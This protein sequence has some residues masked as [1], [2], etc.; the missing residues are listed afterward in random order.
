M[1]KKFYGALLVG[2]L[3]LAGG[4]MVSCSDYDDDINN[5]NE[6]VDALEKTV[7]DLK[8]AIEAGAVITSVEKTENGVKVTLSN[9]EPFEIKNGT[10]GTPG[11]VVTID[12]EGYWCIDGIRQT[13]NEGNPYKAQGQKGDP[14]V[15]TPGADGKDGCWYFPNEDGFW[16]KQYY[17]EEGEIVDEA[18]SISWIPADKATVGVV[19]DSVNGCLKISNIE[20]LGKDEVL[21]IDTWS[22]LKS[23]AVIPTELDTE[24]GMPTVSFFNILKD[25]KTLSSTYAEARFRL[26]PSNANINDWNWKIIERTVATRAAG[27]MEGDW[28]EFNPETDITRSADEMIVRLGAN[29]SESEI[30]ADK[31]PDWRNYEAIF[32]LQG[33]KEAANS[34]SLTSDYIK[35]TNVDLTQFAIVEN[36]PE[37]NDPYQTDKSLIIAATEADFKMAYGGEFNLNEV[38]ATWAKD[39]NEG[40]SIKYFLDNMTLQDGKELTYKFTAEEYRPHADQG[41]NTNNSQY[42]VINDGIVTM[43]P[44]FQ[45][46]AKNRTPLVKVEAQVAG[47]TIATAYIKLQ[48]VDNVNLD[49]LVVK[50]D[51]VAEV[52]YENIVAGQVV[53]QFT[54]EEMNQKVYD[55]LHLSREEF[56]TYYKAKPTYTPVNGISITSVDL[57][58]QNSTSNIIEMSFDPT[59]VSAN[60]TGSIKVTYAPKAAYADT[61]RTVVIEMPYVIS[62]NNDHKLFNFNEQYVAN[63][64]ASIRGKVDPT[65][66]KWA[67]AA[68]ISE[69]FVGLDDL[70]LPDNHKTPVAKLVNTA[71]IAKVTLSGTDIYDQEISLAAPMT[72]KQMD[73]K[74]RIAVPLSND[75]DVDCGIEYTIRFINPF[76]A[77][78]TAIT[79]KTPIGV[80]ADSK[81]IT[82][83]LV[84]KA[85]QDNAKIWYQTAKD[86]GDV[87]GDA[88]TYKVE[89]GDVEFTIEPAEDWSAKFGQNNKN[90]DK[91]TFDKST[92]TVK[93]DNAG[94]SLVANQT[95]HYTATITIGDISKLT[96]TGLIT[97]LS[98]ENS[99]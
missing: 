6:R 66:N 62:H 2:S 47:T 89:D 1:K 10:N 43:S 26:N 16:H 92:Y 94:T 72:E 58:N 49:D 63:G 39:I 71:D 81:A 5:L 42:I 11:S 13:D 29:R 65:T 52:D 35:V 31:T 17:N 19:Y 4:G 60:I 32:A 20:G 54:W 23:L 96:V 74:V 24:T 33:I 61:Y 88:A 69:H 78:A 76:Y 25:G 91:L 56:K 40:T 38:V 21:I 22:D 87:T 68:E 28:L 45:E 53:S 90:N 98:T 93:W 77:E 37:F 86:N 97:I 80:G 8:K 34:Q 57:S 75:E 18:T 79:L 14:G 82:S 70:V 59:L 36:Q 64:I 48:I 3:F 95:T 15:G 83:H 99:K 30:E 44:D 46:S 51:Q 9:G 84:V 73:I 67:M 7:A 12:E 50:A 55:A 41:D 85:T 27:D